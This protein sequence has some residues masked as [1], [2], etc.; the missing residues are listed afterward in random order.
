M[1][2][3]IANEIP[4]ARIAATIVKPFKVVITIF[5]KAYTHT[6]RGQDS[7]RK[8]PC[9]AVSSA[10]IFRAQPSALIQINIKHAV[11]LAD[12]VFQ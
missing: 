4:P 10:A 8:G 1:L 11:M 9:F 5:P 12:L 7:F 6:Q 3:A 2:C